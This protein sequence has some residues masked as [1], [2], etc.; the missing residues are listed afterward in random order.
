MPARAARDNGFAVPDPAAAKPD[1]VAVRHQSTPG[2]HRQ[3]LNDA[4]PCE[5]STSFNTH[6]RSPRL[7][8]NH[9]TAFSIVLVGN[10]IADSALEN[11][12]Q[13]SP[14]GTHISHS[15]AQ[16]GPSS[17]RA[18]PTDQEVAFKVKEAALQA[19]AICSLNCGYTASG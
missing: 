17:E 18:W 11:Q 1:L 16:P 7:S 15:S 5:M 4:R 3:V 12:V 13:A 2:R 14:A 19:A 9:R 10:Q 8:G 6:S